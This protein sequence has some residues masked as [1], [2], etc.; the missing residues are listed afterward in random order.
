MKP[1]TASWISIFI[2]FSAASHSAIPFLKEVSSPF[3]SGLASKEDLSKKLVDSFSELYFYIK[4]KELGEFWVKEDEVIGWKHLA[5]DVRCLKKA[6]LYLGRNPQIEPK[7]FC[8]KSEDLAVLNYQNKRFRVKNDR[9]RIYWI[10]AEDVEW[11]IGS[12]GKA[13]LKR[14]TYLVD[15]KKGGKIWLKAP[16]TL[17]VIRYHKTD[18]FVS[19]GGE[20]YRAARNKFITPL[21]I[22]TDIQFK[23]GKHYPFEIQG[24]KIKAHSKVFAVPAK[25]LLVFN[26]HTIFLRPDSSIY[27]FGDK[28]FLH[29]RNAKQYKKLFSLRTKEETWYQSHIRKHGLVYW[30]DYKHIIN[31][32][33][34]SDDVLFERELYDIASSPLDRK[35]LFASAEGVFRKVSNNQ[36]EPVA[37][38]QNKNYPIHFAKNG[39][40]FIGPYYSDDH[41]KHFKSYIAWH[42]VMKLIKKK[43]KLNIKEV[44]ITKVEALNNSG[45]I[46]K[47]KFSDGKHSQTLK[48]DLETKTWL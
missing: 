6:P 8:K 30:K 20:I 34:L 18:L 26:S 10:S 5:T 25:P 19:F 32:E 11:K 7:H 9:G 17:A 14:D 37:K 2:F 24:L 27:H 3:P 13:V 47:I 44:R 15:L 28:K 35:I 29:V 21:D 48:I 1:I 39:R 23:S 45:S 41:G 22:A 38:F 31:S 43:G 4:D 36:W 33:I 42:K 16:V 46:A 40:L 12:L